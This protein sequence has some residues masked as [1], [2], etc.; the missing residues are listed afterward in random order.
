MEKNE[1]KRKLSISDKENEGL[2]RVRCFNTKG[3]YDPA[4][5]YDNQ[6]IEAKI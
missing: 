3:Y 6:Y 4:L 5:P 2:P 1:Q